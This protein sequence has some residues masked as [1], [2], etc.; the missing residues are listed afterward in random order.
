MRHNVLP[1]LD[2]ITLRVAFIDAIIAERRPRQAV[3]L[4]AGLDTRAW[5]SPALQG[6]RVF[7]LDHP[8]TQ[9][10][11]RER[12]ARLG[13]PLAQVD[14]V[15]IDFTRSQVDSVLAAAGFAAEVPTLWVWE[16]VIM[17]L[18][19]A[20]LRA[21]LRAVRRAS[22]PGSTLV[23][24]YHEPNEDNTARITVMRKL[25]LSL[26]KEPQIGLRSRSVM[27]NEVERAGFHV[28]EDAGLAEQAARVGGTRAP[29]QPAVQM[30]RILV[31]N[32]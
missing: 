14:F 21:T 3:I 5:R 19:D 29:T 28:A 7:E 22:A 11:K 18:D 23:A 25:V 24:H 32:G 13:A 31:A 9:A 8:A 30:S 26:L 2:M 27:R 12:A 10:Y 16:G 17:Y 1:Y 6:V 20:A 4:G 15:P